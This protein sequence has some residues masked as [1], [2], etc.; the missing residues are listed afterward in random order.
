MQYKQRIALK[1]E[2]EA[3]KVQL[4]RILLNLSCPLALQHTQQTE[5]KALKERLEKLCEKL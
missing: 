5:T 3:I 1:K 2:L 4:E